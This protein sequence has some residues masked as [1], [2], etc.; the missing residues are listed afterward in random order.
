MLANRGVDTK[1]EKALRSALHARGLRFRVNHRL[2]VGGVRVRPDMVFTARR[3]CVFSDGCFWHRCPEHATYPKANSDYWGP[4][5]EANI[6]RDRRAD[7]V[8]RETG[9]TVIRVWEHED[10]EKAAD[11]VERAVRAALD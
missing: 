6:A 2:D 9:W 7:R 3:V 10:P 11:R 4:K 8:L 1:P 5:L